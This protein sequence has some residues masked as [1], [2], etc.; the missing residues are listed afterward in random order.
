MGG[1][2]LSLKGGLVD[3]KTLGQFARDIVECL[4]GEDLRLPREGP[5][6]E[7]I[8]RHA[9]SSLE[10]AR[11]HVVVIDEPFVTQAQREALHVGPSDHVVQLLDV[12]GGRFHIGYANWTDSSI[13]VLNSTIKVE[14]LFEES[15][16]VWIVEVLRSKG[17][18]LFVRC[19]LGDD[20]S[21]SDYHICVV[22]RG[23]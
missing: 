21:H 1:P 23:A 2:Q 11:R 19:S 14:R 5:P 9:V 8:R 16:T 7:G 20:R 18:T 17:Y 4:A 3:K 10:A 6:R 15:S 13:A 22:Y 12:T